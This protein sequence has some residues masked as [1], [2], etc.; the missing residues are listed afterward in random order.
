[1]LV[2]LLDTREELVPGTDEDGDTV[3]FPDFASLFN[4][5]YNGTN[6]PGPIRIQTRSSPHNLTVRL[7][8]AQPETSGSHLFFEDDEP[9]VLRVSVGRRSRIVP[10]AP[11]S[12]Y[13]RA[14]TRFYYQRAN[15]ARARPWPA[16]LRHESLGPGIVRNADL[17]RL[18]D[19]VALTD[20]EDLAIEALRLV[21][22]DT[23]DKLTLIGRSDGSR[24]SSERR[25]FVKLRSSPTPVPLKRLGDGANR[26]LALSL[27][28]A[29]AQNGLLLIDEAENGIHHSVQSCLWRFLFRAAET[30]NVQ[31][32]AA[33]HSWDCIAGFAKAAV[34]SPSDGALFRIERFKNRLHAIPYTEENLEIAASQRIEVR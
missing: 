32:V 30:A 22:G 13:T 21:L 20:A 29:N 27:A 2:D 23:V 33:T 3:I 8:E 18:W 7:A 4:D 15:P 14:G 6:E 34:E 10:P 16:P 17:T 11:I 24:P 28:V 25:A 19:A 31:V 12:R 26:L 5:G 1:M 9:R